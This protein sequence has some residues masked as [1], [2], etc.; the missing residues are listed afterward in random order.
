MKCHVS[1]SYSPS[2]KRNFECK[3]FKY[4]PWHN[5]SSNP[6]KATI[7]DP[8]IANLEQNFRPHKLGWWTI[9]QEIYHIKLYPSISS[10][11]SC[12]STSMMMFEFLWILGRFG[13][14]KLKLWWDAN[15]IQ[16]G[17]SLWEMMYSLAS[18][19]NKWRKKCSLRDKNCCIIKKQVS[20]DLLLRSQTG[21]DYNNGCENIHSMQIRGVFISEGN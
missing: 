15:G 2:I 9:S 11:P 17:E 18:K 3:Y 6:H 21:H 5:P 13:W 10:V 20:E 1:L 19:A 7:I 4:Q 12:Q 8:R 16:S 14:M